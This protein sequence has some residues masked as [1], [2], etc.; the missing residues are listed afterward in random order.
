MSGDTFLAR[1]L[2][3]S[4]Q[5]MQGATARSSTYWL[6]GTLVSPKTTT[7]TAATR[8]QH[9]K[10]TTTTAAT[11]QQHSKTTALNEQRIV[12]KLNSEHS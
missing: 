5:G 12:T 9:S 11:H 3:M 2:L 8:Q 1:D 6:R 7:T 4:G 10:T